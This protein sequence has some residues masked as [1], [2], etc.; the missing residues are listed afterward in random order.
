MHTRPGKRLVVARHGHRDE[1]HGDRAGLGCEDGL[2]VFLVMS[3]AV[4][5]SV[6]CAEGPRELRPG[7]ARVIEGMRTLC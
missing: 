7:F 1:T 3:V 4:S 2:A 5:R 6:S